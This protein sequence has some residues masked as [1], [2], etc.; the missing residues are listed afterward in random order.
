MLRTAIN[1]EEDAE[2]T[3]RNAPTRRGEGYDRAQ[4]LENARW[5][6]IGPIRYA[7]WS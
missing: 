3:I 7:E 2:H 6:R 1:S 5:S 4:K